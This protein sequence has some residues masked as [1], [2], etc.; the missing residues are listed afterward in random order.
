VAPSG[1]S[2]AIFGPP[3]A[4][5]R[6]CSAVVFSGCVQRLCS[7]VVFS[8]CVPRLC[9]AVV[10][11]GCVQ[12]LFR[13]SEEVWYFVFSSEVKIMWRNPLACVDREGNR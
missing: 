4:G 13:G 6:A 3:Q 9:S 12:R 10:F 7:A 1:Q 5:N 11:S 2:E 8:G